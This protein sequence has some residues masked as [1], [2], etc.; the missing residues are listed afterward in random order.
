MLEVSTYYAA[1]LG[2]ELSGKRFRLNSNPPAISKWVARS[3][4]AG[5]PLKLNELNQLSEETL[6]AGIRQ[7]M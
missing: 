3:K 5:I 7:K 2:D 6:V 1:E 4:L